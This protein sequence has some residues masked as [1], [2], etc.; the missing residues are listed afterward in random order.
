VGINWSGDRDKTFALAGKEKV[1]ESGAK[2]FR[3]VI[4][5]GCPHKN[6][7]GKE[8]PDKEEENRNDAMFKFMAE[9]QI[10]ILPDVTGIPCR[11]GEPR[12][13]PIPSGSTSRK[14]WENGLKRLAERYGPGGKFWEEHSKGENKLNEAYAPEYWEIWNE[15]NVEKNA[16]EAGNI[17]PGRYGQLLGI[18]NDILNEVNPN[19]KILIGGLLTIGK[20]NTKPKPGEDSG[21]REAE[22]AIWEFLQKV[23]K[24]GHSEDYDA[25]SLH[26]YA[27]KATSVQELTR[28]VLINIRVAR[29]AVNNFGGATISAG[30]AKEI[31][32]TEI[33][34]GV[35]EEGNP[36]RNDGTHIP[37][38]P[39][40]QAERLDS[41]FDMMK[42]HSGS[43]KGGF[44]IAN[45][46]W[47]NI[48]DAFHT[49]DWAYNSGLFTEGGSKRP[50]AFAAFKGQAE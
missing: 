41:V 42:D 16:S 23:K 17:V 45:I 31:W 30:K 10:T 22:M 24:S 40:L 11:P 26:P 50:L 46:F 21:E 13:P 44:K 14:R 39:T 19:I 27:F 2:M 48:Q 29:G 9:E 20:T 15:E 36:V 28:K 6:K 4:N 35:E 25:V 18:S 5:P 49:D 34:W 33:G 47:Y 8:V 3:V 32:I 37:V 43:G 1:A 38:D 12:L 7:E